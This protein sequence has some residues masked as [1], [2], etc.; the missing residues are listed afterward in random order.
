MGRVVSHV[1]VTRIASNSLPKGLNQCMEQGERCDRDTRLASVSAGSRPTARQLGSLRV[2]RPLRLAQHSGRVSL[3]F[4]IVLHA[5]VSATSSRTRLCTCMTPTNVR[6]ATNT[7]M[8]YFA[9]RQ[10]RVN[11][12][13]AARSRM[14][15][16]GSERPSNGPI[17]TPCGTLVFI[18]RGQSVEEKLCARWLTMVLGG[19]PDCCSRRRWRSYAFRN[20]AR[21]ISHSTSASSFESGCA[22]CAPD[23]SVVPIPLLLLLMLWPQPAQPQA[24]EPAQIGVARLD[25]QLA[26]PVQRLDRIDPVLDVVQLCQEESEV[27]RV[28]SEARG[29]G[30]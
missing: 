2:L 15:A 4:T 24:Q 22:S 23:P 9:C 19:D 17:D 30:R 20:P 25:R 16:A 8:A 14:P 28:S 29:P 18:R 10:G 3:H 27:S 7:F 11:R 21:S 13:S 1:V 12:R 26:R 6:C 5:Q